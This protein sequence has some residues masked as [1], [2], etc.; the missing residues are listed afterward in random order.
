MFYLA[1]DGTIQGVRVEGSSSW[2]SNPPT[3]VL[4]GPYYLPSGLAVRSYDVA[5][6]GTRFLMIKNEGSP[7]R[8]SL[9]IVENWHEELKRLVPTR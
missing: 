8:Q 2:R 4:Q 7:D 9:V 3:K 5:P 1:P 6:D